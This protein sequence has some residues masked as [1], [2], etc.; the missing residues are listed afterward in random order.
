M[1]LLVLLMWVGLCGCT[2]FHAKKP[3]ALDAPELTITGAPAGS[4]VFIDGVQVGTANEAATHPQNLQV[5]PG[6]HILEVRTGDAVVYR[7]NFDAIAG[8]KRVIAVL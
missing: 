7:E 4:I 6:T 3:S 8:E 2:W 1:K 5:A